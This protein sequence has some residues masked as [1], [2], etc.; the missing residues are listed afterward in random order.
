M[1]AHDDDGVDSAL[2]LIGLG[3]LLLGAVITTIKAL[4]VLGL[5]AGL[6]LLFL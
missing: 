4:L 6:V 1:A 2:L 5:L 3:G